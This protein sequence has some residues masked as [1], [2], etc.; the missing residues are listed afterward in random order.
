MKFEI[1]YP[2]VTALYIVDWQ[3]GTY[4][5]TVRVYANDAE[6]ACAVAKKRLQREGVLCLP[7]AYESFKARK[8]GEEK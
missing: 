8:A 3:H 4:K 6:H 5:G 1:D 2:G 7:M